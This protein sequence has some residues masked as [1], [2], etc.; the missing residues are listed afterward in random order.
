MRVTRRLIVL[1]GA[2]G[3]SVSP[4]TTPPPRTAAA[5][6]ASSPG[7]GDAAVAD[8]APRPLDR[9]GDF[10]PI[11]EGL[12]DRRGAPQDH[13][14]TLTT[15]TE[16]ITIADADLGTLEI[17]PLDD[18]HRTTS[19]DGTWAVE[20]NYKTHMIVAGPLVGGAIARPVV[21]HRGAP[22]IRFVGA[23]ELQRIVVLDNSNWG[24]FLVR[25]QDG[26][27][28]W[29]ETKLDVV[30]SS[31][32][33][34][35]RTLDLVTRDHQWVRIDRNGDVA[36]TPITEVVPDWF[37]C[38]ST[39]LWVRRGERL[40]WFDDKTHGSVA[41]T[42]RGPMICAGDAVLVPVDGGVTRCTHAGCG[43]VQA[44]GDFADLTSNGIATATQHANTVR[45]A[46]TDRAEIDVALDDGE[47]LVGMAVWNDVPTLVLLGPGK[48]LRLATSR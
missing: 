16:R 5:P 25:S 14:I 28:T 23:S 20:T 44:A 15:A 19:P 32:A 38:A 31:I 35:R 43:P 42:A 7:I 13:E 3:S 21:V 48:R 22:P 36:T 26:G 46:L 45:I 30:S 17:A 10:G 6:P 11:I 27:K 34:S 8:A 40:D 1:F 12:P 37:T 2:C 4:T 41:A 39:N 18:A 24:W 47:H 9:S 33:T 29:R